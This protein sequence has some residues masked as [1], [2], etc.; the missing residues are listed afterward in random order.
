MGQIYKVCCPDCGHSFEFSQGCG[1]FD[2]TAVGRERHKQ[3]ILTG[4]FGE[5]L[6][7]ILEEHPDALVSYSKELLYCDK[8]NQYENRSVYRIYKKAQSEGSNALL[9]V[10]EYDC[11]KCHQPMKVIGGRDG[12]YFAEPFTLACP[13]CKSPAR[14]SSVLCFD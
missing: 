14:I 9:F 5:K 3:K 13:R 1:R 12:A 7:K 10:L 2:C 11:I 8:C 4:A 6:K